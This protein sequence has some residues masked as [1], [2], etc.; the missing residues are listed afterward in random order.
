MKRFIAHHELARDSRFIRQDNIAATTPATRPAGADR[1]VES[2]ARLP[3][4]MEIGVR[5]PEAEPLY[6]EYGPAFGLVTLNEP[7]K[8]GDGAA[9]TRLLLRMHGI[10][11]GE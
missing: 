10:F 11:V 6:E 4:I 8:P 5:G 3:P 7:L 1:V 9:T 2:S